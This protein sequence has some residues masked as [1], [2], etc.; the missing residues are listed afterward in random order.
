[1]GFLCGVAIGYLYSQ[2]YA[3][4]SVQVE[5]MA[6]SHWK[7]GDSYYNSIIRFN[8]N[9]EGLLVSASPQVFLGGNLANFFLVGKGQ[10]FGTGPISVKFDT[11]AADEETTGPYKPN[12]NRGLRKKGKSY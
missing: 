1:M 4:A 5:R 12:K 6:V 7:E 9:F 2:T 10:N 3:L 11:G 8:D